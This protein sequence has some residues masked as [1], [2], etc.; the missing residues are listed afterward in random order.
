MGWWGQGSTWMGLGST[1]VNQNPTRWIRNGGCWGGRLKGHGVVR[2]GVN[3]DGVGVN[4][5]ESESYSVNQKWRVLRGS[6]QRSWG[7]EVRGQPGWGWWGQGSTRVNQNHQFSTTTLISWIRH[8]SNQRAV[9][10]FFLK[11]PTL[12]MTKNSR[13]GFN[14][15]N[16]VS[17]FPLT[18]QSVTCSLGYPPPPPPTSFLW[19]MLIHHIVLLTS[20][21]W[22]MIDRTGSSESD[23]VA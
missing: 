23:A 17:D 7:G 11:L 3:L 21:L 19:T 2:S 1:R 8:C 18:D 12:I 15:I 4:P 6:P 5:G 16:F 13:L 9:L 10:D 22:T 20:F 14:N